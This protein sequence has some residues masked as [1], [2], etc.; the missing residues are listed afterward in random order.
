MPRRV[1]MGDAGASIT[2]KGPL[3]R[4]SGAGRRGSCRACMQPV[5]N[6]KKGNP[7][8]PNVSTLA[9]FNQKKFQKTTL[10]PALE[11][12]VQAHT[13]LLKNSRE[14][15]LLDKKASWGLSQE[16]QERGWPSWLAARQGELLPAAV[17]RAGAS[18]PCSGR[19]R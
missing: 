2:A 16:G 11:R 7:P 10:K 1:G 8:T 13:L 19:R 3:P 9:I 15:D 18:P 12:L 14:E 6:R 5:L 17:G 4:V